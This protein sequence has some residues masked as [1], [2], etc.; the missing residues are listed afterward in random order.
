M[1]VFKANQTLSLALVGLMC[2]VQVRHC[3]GSTEILSG[4][5]AMCKLWVNRWP[6]EEIEKISFLTSI[7]TMR[8]IPLTPTDR[9]IEKVCL[10]SEDYAANHNTTSFWALQDIDTR[11]FTG[12]FRHS[13]LMHVYFG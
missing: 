12:A 3:H 6:L 8:I 9:V 13:E 10:V 7:D 4:Y 2:D 5:D 11:E 1:E